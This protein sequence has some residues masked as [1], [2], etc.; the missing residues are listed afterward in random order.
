MALM[1]RPRAAIDPAIRKRLTNVAKLRDRAETE[2]R[3]AVADAL[4]VGVPIRDIAELAK[5]S[6]RTVQDWKAGR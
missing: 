1:P 3:S 4:D 6:T 2:S 5:L